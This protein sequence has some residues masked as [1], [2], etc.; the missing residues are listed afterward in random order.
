MVTLLAAMRP[1]KLQV[2][3]KEPSNPRPVAPLPVP[4]VVGVVK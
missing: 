1:R 2:P 4:M 3:R